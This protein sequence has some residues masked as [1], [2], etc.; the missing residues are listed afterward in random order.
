MKYSEIVITESPY[1]VTKKFGGWPGHPAEFQMGDRLKVIDV[2]PDGM[3]TV[4][5]PDGEE[6]GNKIPLAHLR[7]A[8][9]D[10]SLHEN[11]GLED[12]EE[13]ILEADIDDMIA[14]A[15]KNLQTAKKYA[16][17]P[18]GNWQS[19]DE[20]RSSHEELEKLRQQKRRND[21]EVKSVTFTV[22]SDKGSEIHT[23]LHKLWKGS[24]AR[25]PWGNYHHDEEGKSTVAFHDYI[26]GMKAG[27]EPVEVLIDYVKQFEI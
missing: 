11:F 14:Q 26:P 4:T 17:S 22:P 19:R 24:G 13:A 2:G 6:I 8:G 5:L 23:G 7:P 9:M 21:G 18:A 16:D 27:G 20:V 10:E 3:A 12:L 1:I 15:E 25:L